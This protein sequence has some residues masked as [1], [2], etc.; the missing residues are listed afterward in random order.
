MDGR[1]VLSGGVGLGVP[2]KLFCFPFAGGNVWAF[3]QLARR[4]EGRIEVCPI[5]PPGRGR[6][7]AEPCIDQW[8]ALVEDLLGE[9]VPRLS[10]PYAFLG[11]SLG[12]LVALE[13]A[14]ELAARS[15]PAL[16]APVALFACA[17][18][19]P[20]AITHGPLM[21]RMDDMAM[22]EAVR[23]LGGI[24][25]QVLESPELIALSAPSLRADLTLYE[26]YVPRRQP[27]HRVPV[28]AYH[29][30][31]DTSVDDTYL[32]WRDETDGTFHARGFDGAHMFLDSATDALAE[33]LMTDLTCPAAPH[34]LAG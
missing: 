20:R 15:G 16:A 29:G 26:T 14:H 27:L 18:R 6:R 5:E 2:L 32:S 9:L 25:D 28:H 13:A 7:R 8:P 19:G 21:H 11:Y 22:F 12:A 31:G 10:G 34:A 1:P 33:A 3:R 23:R 17:S 24:P 4:L 30:R